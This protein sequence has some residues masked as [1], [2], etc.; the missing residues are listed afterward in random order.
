ME[1]IARRCGIVEPEA[2]ASCLFCRTRFSSRV[3]TELGALAGFR[4]LWIVQTKVD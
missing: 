1:L 2:R 3:Q 4:A